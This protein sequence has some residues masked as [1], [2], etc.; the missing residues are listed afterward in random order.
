M[1]LTIRDAT[2]ADAARVA[3]LLADIDYPASPE[4]AAA[5]IARFADDPASRLQVADSADGVVGLVATHI[6]PRLDRDRLSCRITDIVVSASHRRRGIASALVEAATDEARRAG[7]Q[8]LD[9]SS[10]EW[11]ADAYAFYTR[12][13]FTTQSRGFTKRLADTP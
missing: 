8:R 11:R 9:L 13:G 3:A 1:E 12:M 4:A 6:V 10:G 5:H 2:Q 7:A